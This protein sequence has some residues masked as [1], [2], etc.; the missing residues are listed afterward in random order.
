MKG[1]G[2]VGV[3]ASFHEALVVRHQT[4]FAVLLELDDRF[5]KLIRDTQL[6]RSLLDNIS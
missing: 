4:G 6:Y 1:P 3:N 5:F 2:I